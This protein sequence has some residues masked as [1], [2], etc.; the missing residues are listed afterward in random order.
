[1]LV[2]ILSEHVDDLHTVT[3]DIHDR[4]DTEPA[5]ETAQTL[6]IR[7]EF[8]PISVSDFKDMMERGAELTDAM[9]PWLDYTNIR[10]VQEKSR[11]RFTTHIQSHGQGPLFGDHFFC[12]T[13]FETDDPIEVFYEFYYR[14]GG[15]ADELLTDDVDPR[16]SIAG[17]VEKYREDSVEKTLLKV[18]RKNYYHG[19]H[20]RR[21]QYNHHCVPTVDILT[22]GRI[23]TLAEN[24]P[25]Q[26]RSHE[27]ELPGK[28]P[29]I[30]DPVPRLKLELITERGSGIEDI[31]YN[32]T[33][34]PPSTPYWQ[35]KLRY[36]LGHRLQIP[37]FRLPSG[38]PT[39]YIDLS[40]NDEEFRT[41][42]WDLVESVADRP[43]VDGDALRELA[44]QH[45]SGEA[46]YIRPISILTSLEVW[47]QRYFD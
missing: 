9:V 21:E 17:E 31:K 5:R 10:Y 14:E 32:R 11:S 26:Y 46:D 28:I 13:H 18:N 41:M 34:H 42:L 30:I 35:Q 23:L 20:H 24:M 33:Q 22:N 27:R 43:F 15:Y 7:N 39:T 3:Y 19:Y 25:R 47:L 37:G 45:F 4:A 38:F 29:S 8:T 1:M 2:S 40:R 6:R 44:N 12:E 16:D 36:W